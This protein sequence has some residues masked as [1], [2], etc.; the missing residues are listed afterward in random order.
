MPRISRCNRLKSLW[1][2]CDAALGADRDAAPSSSGQPSCTGETQGD[3]GGACSAAVGSATGSPPG[4][5]TAGSVG[6]AC[7]EEEKKR[8]T[9][10]RNRENAQNSR[11]RKKMMQEEIDKKTQRLEGENRS[12]WTRG[13]LGV[14]A[15]GRHQLD[16]KVLPVEAPRASALWRAG[17]EGLKG[18][19]QHMEPFLA[20]PRLGQ[21]VKG[22][23]GNPLEDLLG[24]S[25]RESKPLP[26]RRCWRPCARWQPSSPRFH[27]GLRP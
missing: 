6:T 3:D 1:S 18:T 5:Q 14:T 10:I 24:P 21:A 16:H 9:R 4:R 7:E 11:R 17:L 13:L 15:L 19:A 8:R 12:L 2:G 27:F 25:P 26:Q 20:R 23:M 22:T